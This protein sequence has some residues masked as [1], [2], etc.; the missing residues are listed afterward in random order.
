[1]VI[2]T[3]A[4]AANAA[5][6][7]GTLL[8]G[9]GLWSLWIGFAL[10]FLITASGFQ[11]LASRLCPGITLRPALPR[12]PDV[13]NV[14]K[15]AGCLVLGSL[16]ASLRVETDK[17]VL[18]S[19][20]S[21]A[22]TGYYSLAAR[23]AGL[24]MEVSNFFYVPTVA[25]AGALHA[26]ADWPGIRALYSRLMVVV[27]AAAGAVIVAVAGFPRHLMVLWIGRDVPQAVPL[28]G[29]LLCGYASAVVL[30]GPGT[31]ICKGAGR[32]EIETA[33]IAVSLALNL[34]LT[35]ILVRW[36][37]PIGTVIA[38]AV[39]WAAG[40]LFF[41]FHLHRRLPLRAAPTIRAGRVFAAIIAILMAI[42]FASPHLGLPAGRMAAGRALA[43]WLPAA[44][45]LYASALLLTGV[46]PM[47]VWRALAGFCQ[48][49]HRNPDP[50]RQVHV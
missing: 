49:G 35:I 43:A 30:T 1:M 18:A 5:G 23:M 17:L 25:A 15:Y 40:S 22:W 10:A 29:L 42:R 27:P 20:A 21:P 12:R 39:S 9:A 7:I 31:C 26:R 45:V 48:G 6:T 3:A 47:D 44:M 28:L 14:R 16:S 41:V 38:T 34:G 11:I 32:I 13:R 46:V 8:L 50:M 36:V 4:S 24:V 33:Y 19:F 37:G 2:Q